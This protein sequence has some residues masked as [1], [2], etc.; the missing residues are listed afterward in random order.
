MSMVEAV[1]SIGL[2]HCVE[3]GVINDWM[4]YALYTVRL[5]MTSGKRYTRYAVVVNGCWKSNEYFTKKGARERVA[6]LE[7]LY[8]PKM[9]YSE[10]IG[11][12][13]EYAPNMV[14][15]KACKLHD[16]DNLNKYVLVYKGVIVG[17][18]LVTAESVR[19]YIK[20]EV[21]KQKEP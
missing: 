15:Y 11:L 9:T 6:I 18:E 13:N 5:R 4:K 21:E 7:K 14:L 3:R 19:E 8:K 16:E 17:S 1:I 10:M 12:C 2:G 20:T